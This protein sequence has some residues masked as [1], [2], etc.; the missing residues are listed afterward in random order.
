VTDS[1]AILKA[2]GTNM[3]IPIL[4]DIQTAL[5]VPSM[6]RQALNTL[7]GEIPADWETGSVK[8]TLRT[9]RER[10]EELELQEIRRAGPQEYLLIKPLDTSGHSMT[11]V[12]WSGSTHEIRRCGQYARHG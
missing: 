8:E 1:Q 11:S 4:D 2:Q 9:L 3:P 10:L 6:L 12:L 7:Q 5:A